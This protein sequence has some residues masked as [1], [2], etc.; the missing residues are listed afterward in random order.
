MEG[1][2]GLNPSIADIKIKHTTKLPWGTLYVEISHQYPEA[3]QFA[4]KDN[5]VVLFMSTI[6][7]GSETIKR[8]RKRPKNGDAIT[9]RTW[10][11]AFEKELEV[12]CFID[13]YNHHMNGVDL[14]DQGRA[15]C[16]TKR[17]TCL[18]WKPCFS[19]MF[20]T[21][22]C[23]MAKL[24]EACGHYNKRHKRG[25]N[26]IFRRLLASKLMVK[27]A[28][29]AYMITPGIK[30]GHRT[31]LSDV[32]ANG[33][34]TQTTSQ[35]HSQDGE[36]SQNTQHYGDL[37]KGYKQDTCKACQAGGR[38]ASRRAT[39]TR[40]V[41]GEISTNATKRAPRTNYQCGQCLIAL[42]NTDL[43]WQE[44]LAAYLSNN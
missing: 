40:V 36:A 10:G 37:V 35:L 43:C 39:P 28:A 20:D 3:I 15:E 41:L 38:Y 44:H 33:S 34:R 25:L 11:E 6:H 18:T 31:V 5:N 9:K 14:A 12:P 16:P 32:V 13:S 4:W 22:L 21:S 1:N 29:R 7:T 17:R 42:C 19:F 30:P 24:Y 2:Q 27:A 8:N 23:N 26:N